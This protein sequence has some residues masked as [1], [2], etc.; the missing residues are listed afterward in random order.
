MHA[1]LKVGPST[2]QKL[3]KVRSFKYANL[4]VIILVLKRGIKVRSGI[5]SVQLINLYVND[6][7]CVYESFIHIK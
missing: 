3:L 6:S 2:L 5:W 4:N 1:N 7:R